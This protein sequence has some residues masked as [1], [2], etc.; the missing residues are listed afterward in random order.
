MKEILLDIRDWNNWEKDRFKDKDY[1]TL[2]DLLADYQDLILE[3]ERLEEQYNDL[4]KDLEDNY[5][6]RPMSDYTGSSYDD[7]F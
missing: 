7:R 4:Q 1:I 2:Y 5:V 3:N 6:S